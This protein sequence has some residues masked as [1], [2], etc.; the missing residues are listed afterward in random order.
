[1]NNKTVRVRKSLKK[2]KAA[3]TKVKKVDHNHVKAEFYL[4]SLLAIAENLSAGAVAAFVAH[5]Y[6]GDGGSNID[7]VLYFVATS[8]YVVSVWMRSILA[9]KNAR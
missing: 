2:Y 8:L 6:F 5:W 3:R 4:A 7:I 1:M 9:E